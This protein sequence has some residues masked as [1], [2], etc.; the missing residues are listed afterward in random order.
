MTDSLKDVPAVAWQPEMSRPRDDAAPN[1]RQQ[2]LEAAA[3]TFM[4]HGY[5][6][7]SIDDIADRLGATKGRVYHYYRSKLDILLDI[8]ISILE[9]M[10]NGV[11]PVA[12]DGSSA[13]ARLDRMVRLHALSVIY[14]MPAAQVA[15]HTVLDSF[16]NQ[17]QMEAISRINQLRRDY[18]EAFLRVI[19]EG[20]HDGD[21]SVADSQLAAKAALGALNWITV[22][23][24]APGAGR[25]S[26]EAVAGALAQFVLRGLGCQYEA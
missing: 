17:K 24:R 6:G 21:F 22:W 20:E 23:Y 2:L 10:T 9:H 19:E 8:N 7:A 25:D 16:S 5:S 14:N 18:E 12:D 4:E 1:R 15:L 3:E 13:A 11:A 26:P